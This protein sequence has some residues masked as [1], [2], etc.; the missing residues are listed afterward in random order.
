MTS[1]GKQQYKIVSE[2]VKV[3]DLLYPTLSLYAQGLH[4]QGTSDIAG[5]TRIHHIDP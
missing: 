4:G 1:Y 2:V 5:I 3:T